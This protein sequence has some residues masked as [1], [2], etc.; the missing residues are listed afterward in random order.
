VHPPLPSD[1]P[2]R[3]LH[4]LKRRGTAS[5]PEL[6][7]VEGLN[8]ESIRAHVR[9]LLD[10]GLLEFRGERVQGRGRPE[11]LYGLARK[12]E[13]RFPRR[14]SE[15]LQGLARYLREAG[16]QALLDGF[17]ESF[18]REREAEARTR[19]DGLSGRER[20]REVVQILNE[21]GYM[22]ELHEGVGGEAPLLRLCHC[23][24]RELVDVTR[25]PCRVEI[26]FVRALV[27]ETLARVEYIPDGGHA[28]AYTLAASLEGQPS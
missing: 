17:L 21:E 27:G 18:A 13:S 2:G 26:G 9:S 7:E 19:L 8:P 6:A 14:E 10:E 15:L 11:R 5:I 4:R 16:H 28:C 23:P 12:A 25:T 22:A 20:L 3:I 24:V 1:T